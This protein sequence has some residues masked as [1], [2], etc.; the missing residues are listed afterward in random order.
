M[1]AASDRIGVKD[2][3][4]WH[5]SVGI[6]Q[7]FQGLRTRPVSRDFHRFDR[8]E[9]IGGESFGRLLEH[10]VQLVATLDGHDGTFVQRFGAPRRLA[11]RLDIVDLVHRVAQSP[12]PRA[13]DPREPHANVDGPIGIAVED[14]YQVPTITLPRPRS[15]RALVCGSTRLFHERD[16]VTHIPAAEKELAQA[17]LESAQPLVD[18][19]ET[20]PVVDVVVALAPAPEPVRRH[21][22]LVHELRRPDVRLL[23]VQ[24]DADVPRPHDV[25]D[26]QLAVRLGRSVPPR[27]SRIFPIGDGIHHDKRCLRCVQPNGHALASPGRTH[28]AGGEAGVDTER[29]RRVDL[30]QFRGQCLAHRDHAL[31]QS[32]QVV[33]QL[34]L[35]LQPVVAVLALDLGLQVPVLEVLAEAVVAVAEGLAGVVE[36][37]GPVGLQVEM[38]PVAMPLTGQVHYGFQ[39]LVPRAPFERARHVGAFALAEAAPWLV[40]VASGGHVIGEAL[41]AGLSRQVHRQPSLHRLCLVAY[42]GR[43]ERR[44]VADAVVMGLLGAFG[45][46]LPIGKD[47]RA[48]PLKVGH[49]L[50]DG[51]LEVPPLGPEE[52]DLF[53]LA[54]R[55][56]C[57]HVVVGCRAGA[58]CEP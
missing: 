36:P 56:Q 14:S 53:F 28:I 43:R 23:V 29:E 45:G 34:A 57:G 19:R 3:P 24:H 17:A 15:Q 44:E 49:G 10:Q 12:W 26:P 37:V 22:Q 35:F 47:G 18:H 30:P 13:A 6:R 31:P 9:A 46:G 58:G 4:R 52:S 38:Q 11:A 20:T 25:L 40:G 50:L 42:L 16:E 2:R 55:R 41:Q 7:W 21:G 33:I 27:A 5:G 1:V 39:G 32:R 48:H 54:D 51:H 8:K